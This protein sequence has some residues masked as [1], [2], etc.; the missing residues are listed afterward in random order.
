VVGEDQSAEIAKLTQEKSDLKQKLDEKTE[1]GAKSLEQACQ[2]YINWRAADTELAFRSIIDSIV[3]LL[4]VEGT[5]YR[6]NFYGKI[7]ISLLGYIET[8]GFWDFDRSI[9]VTLD[10]PLCP[11]V[12]IGPIYI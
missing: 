4:G 10:S 1:C 12:G 5:D 9:S 2:K 11:D 8:G 3:V 7:G 6:R